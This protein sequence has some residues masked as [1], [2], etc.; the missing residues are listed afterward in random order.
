MRVFRVSDGHYCYG[1]AQ[2]CSFLNFD[3]RLHASL[4]LPCASKFSDHANCRT[5][6][7]T[8][9]TGAHFLML[10]YSRGLCTLAYVNYLYAHTHTHISIIHSLS[11]SFFFLALRMFIYGTL[12]PQSYDIGAVGLTQ[13]LHKYM[14][15][16]V[17]LFQ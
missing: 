11:L 17:S 15:L 8:M 2:Y 10:G 7:V 14:D 3:G 6:I 4:S 1:D 5:T 13:S 12:G 9:L 16:W